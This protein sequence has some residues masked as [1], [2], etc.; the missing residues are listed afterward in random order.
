MIVCGI[1]YSLTSPSICVHSGEQWDSKN[2][3]F[4][5][6]VNSA[7]KV[8]INSQFKGQEYPEYDSDTKRY[9]NL[10]SWSSSIIEQHDVGNCFIEGYAF[11]AV[12]R[13]FQI[14]ENTGLL[15]YY[16]WKSGRK[17]DVFAP[18]AI[19]KFATTKGNA[20][21]E[22]MYECFLEETGIDIRKELDIKSN[23]QWNPLSDIVD[24]YFIAKMG[25]NYLTNK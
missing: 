15:K 8:V 23:K 5:Y 7:K 12:G 16:L 24:S 18:P 9:D 25:F 22:M 11:N 10:S 4:Y 13:V 20:N 17:F 19:K 14:A 1:D 6:L 21:K 2:C 3:V